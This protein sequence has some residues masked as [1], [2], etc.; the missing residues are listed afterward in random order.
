MKVS[1]I[2]DYEAPKGA[3][4][5]HYSIMRGSRANLV[6]RQ[7]AEQKFQPTLYI[8]PVSLSGQALE[9][10]VNRAVAALQSEYP[11]VRAEA[12]GTAYKLVVPDKY[13]VGHEAHFA[14][15]TEA[16]L[17]Y[18]AAGRLPKWEVPNMLVKH[19]TIMQA[20]EMSRGGSM[21][22]AL[23][24]VSRFKPALGRAFAGEWGVEG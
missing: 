23:P 6:I 3:G 8:E 1:V 17:G 16:Y 24:G 5:T 18:L 10:E 11:G 14:Q 15:V 4:D 7:G 22:W 12:V 20:F 21:A 9:R 13:Q 19:H 2:W